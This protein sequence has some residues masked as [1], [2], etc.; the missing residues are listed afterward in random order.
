MKCRKTDVCTHSPQMDSLSL[1]YTMT[2]LQQDLILENLDRYSLVM[3]QIF[4]DHSHQH[5]VN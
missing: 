5:Y 4:K 3:T 2:E 1:A